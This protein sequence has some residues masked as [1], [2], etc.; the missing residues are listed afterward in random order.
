LCVSP[1]LPPDPPSPPLSTSNGFTSTPPI[2]ESPL[3]LDEFEGIFCKVRPSVLEASMSTELFPALAFAYIWFLLSC[4]GFEIGGGSIRFVRDLIGYRASDCCRCCC[5]GGLRRRFPSRC[6][7]S[8]LPVLCISVPSVE[9]L[10]GLGE[11]IIGRV[12]RLV[13][14]AVLIPFKG[15]GR[16]VMIRAKDPEYLLH[17]LPRDDECWATIGGNREQ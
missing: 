6:E 15:L 13:S 1:E 14:S 10:C 11:G 5:S 9:V 12:L 7:A 2:N 17:W 16:R 4:F 8:E 3:P